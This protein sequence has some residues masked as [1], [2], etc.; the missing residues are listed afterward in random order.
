MKSVSVLGL[1]LAVSSSVLGGCVVEQAE[2]PEPEQAAA[3]SEKALGTVVR[4]K[5]WSSGKT[6]D[7]SAWKVFDCSSYGPDY[8]LRALEVFKEPSS[9]LDN[10]IARMDGQCAVGPVTGATST[11]DTVIFTAD[12]R[13]DSARMDSFHKWLNY[14]S[15]TGYWD[16]PAEGIRLV[17]NKNEY[18]KNLRFEYRNWSAYA[19]TYSYAFDES[20]YGGSAETLMCDE[21][22]IV[23]GVKLRYDTT[24]GKIRDFKV[25]CRSK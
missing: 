23:T 14:S 21:G 4:E 8:F 17:V 13:D 15:P 12:H 1:V 6:S 9:N 24:K 10:F 16:T 11:G 22:W 7:L 5:G 19:G 18:V 3:T 2:R 20:A 25:M